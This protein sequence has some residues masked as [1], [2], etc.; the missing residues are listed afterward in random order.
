VILKAPS[1]TFVCGEYGVLAGGQGLVW[2]HGPSF[3]M[4]F[5]T[6]QIPKTGFTPHPLSP[7]GQFLSKHSEF[8]KDYSFEFNDPHQGRGGFG[9]SGAQFLFLWAFLKKKMGLPMDLETLMKDFKDSDL[10]ASSGCD[11]LSQL[12][13]GLAQVNPQMPVR[14]R[15]LLW[16]F[17]HLEVFLI[18]TGVKIS[19]HDHLKNLER[20]ELEDL[21]GFGERA[22]QALEA[23][24][25]SDFFGTL[26]EFRDSLEKKNL[27][28]ESS[29]KLLS[30]FQNLA[31]L[32]FAKACGAFGSDTLLFF[33]EKEQ[34]NGAVHE[35]RS[36]GFEALCLSRPRDDK[37]LGLVIEGVHD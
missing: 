24:K 15:S 23:Q 13:G 25:E 11:V 35:F 12:V 16:P 6:D 28:V 8:F 20:S 31:G 2:T 3:E 32:R 19:T 4:K 7:A 17:P 1:K 30:Q 5:S 36:R 10:G 33:V 27:V 14:S 29:L 21:K 37:S 34:A 18:S 22:S 26:Q 9:A